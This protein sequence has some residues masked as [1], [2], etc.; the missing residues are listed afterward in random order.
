[1][2]NTLKKNIPQFVLVDDDEFALQLTTKLIRN[3]SRHAG[4]SIFYSAKDAIECM[5]NHYFMQKTADTVLL[6]DLHMPGMDG[7]A[8]LDRLGPTFKAMRGRLHIFVMSAEAGTDEKRRIL[9]YNHVIGVLDKP[10]SEVTM[11]QVLHCIQCP[12]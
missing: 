9:A 6:T 5:E 7:F 2:K 11:R 4:I 1:M 10:L 8:L 3:I 12:I